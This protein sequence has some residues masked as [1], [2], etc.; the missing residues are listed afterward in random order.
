MARDKKGV[1]QK[2]WAGLSSLS[3]RTPNPDFDHGYSDEYTSSLFPDRRHLNDVLC[4]VTAACN[5]MNKFGAALPYD[6]E[7]SYGQ[8]AVVTGSNGVVYVSQQDDNL[9][10]DPIVAGNRPLYWKA[11]LTTL[12][13]FVNSNDTVAVTPKGV[14]DYV[15][16]RIYPF[17]TV[18]THPT[19]NLTLP[20]EFSAG[21]N[22][23]FSLMS[24]GQITTGHNNVYAYA[25][26]VLFSMNLR[27][28]S[29]TS[30]S[31]KL[32]SVDDYMFVYVDGALVANSQNFNN[33]TSPKNISFSIAAGNHLVQIVKNNRGG[34]DWDFDFVGDL[35]KQNSFFI[36]P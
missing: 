4:K 8:Y 1:F 34:G 15:E 35:V 9:N 3:D 7:L 12:Q 18:R 30:Y 25:K 33:Q 27:V 31:F 29:T 23:E 21:F 13:G 17:Y 36:K 14:L 5:D 2:V 22:S 28:L 24:M 6:E 10:H 20:S 32:F 16:D 26:S 19:N 11:F